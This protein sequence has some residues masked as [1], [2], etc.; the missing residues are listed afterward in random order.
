MNQPNRNGAR[1]GDSER[2]WTV[3]RALSLLAVAVLAGAWVWAFSP[4]APRG[5]PDRMEDRTFPEQA[6]VVCSAARDDLAEIPRAFEAEDPAGRA[7]FID[8]AT[9]RLAEMI[10][11]LADIAPEPVDEDSRT[12][13]LWLEDWRTYLG[14]RDRYS[15]VLRSGDDPAFTVTERDGVGVT[16]FVD[17]F[18][19]ANDMESCMIPLDV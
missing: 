12:V 9:D 6:E 15:V 17:G 11:D 5:H 7:D 13:Q 14:D 1:A 3:G 4:F 10:D 2:F 16:E 18:A 19:D 8:T